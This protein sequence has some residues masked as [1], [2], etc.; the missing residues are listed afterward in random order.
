MNLTHL[1]QELPG[2][3]PQTADAHPVFQRPPEAE[4]KEAYEDVRFDPALELVGFVTT[5]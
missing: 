5:D 3:I 1:E 2:L 4:R